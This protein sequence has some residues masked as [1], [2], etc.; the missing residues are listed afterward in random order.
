MYPRKRILTEIIL[1]EQDELEEES[2]ED[3]YDKSKIFEF[4]TVDSRM[5]KNTLLESKFLNNRLSKEPR[6]P[7]LTESMFYCE[8]V[9]KKGIYGGQLVA[10]EN[11]LEFK[12]LS[13]YRLPQKRA[14]QMS[15]AKYHQ[16]N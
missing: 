10:K 2:E 14:Y 15:T 1:S 6:E 12:Y 4:D 8:Y 16:I 13:H 9:T 11:F 3:N 5:R 7:K